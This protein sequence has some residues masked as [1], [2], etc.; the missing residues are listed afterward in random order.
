MKNL[1]G[2]IK[3][4]SGQVLVLAALL[5]TVLMG[6]AAFAVDIGMVTVT[7]AKLQSTADA[8]VL[9]AVQVLN[10]S[11]T[12]D[13]AINYAL[14]NGM[15]ATTNG[16][17]QSGDT[18]T[19]TTPYN[20]DSNLIEVVCSRNVKYTF[21]RVLGFNETKV[22]ARAVAENSKW[23]GDVL[24]FINLD[25]DGEDSN[26]G[27]PLTAWNKCDPSGV[28]E[29]INNDDLIIKTSSI[30]VKLED[31]S[32]IFKDGKDMSQVQEPLKN[33]LVV[34]KTVYI[35]S[36]KHS[37]MPNYEKKGPKELK[38]GDLIP[39]EDTVLLEC[40]VTDGW[41]GTGSDLIDLK[42]IKSYNWDASKKTYL[43]DEGDEPGG[44]IRLVK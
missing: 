28:K 44:S 30:K 15:K 19:V 25:G 29:R 34:G 17:E 35:I 7:K 41:T 16:V 13:V 26:E 6:F 42:F 27:E 39:L 33:I 3:N 5:M 40:E 14:Q 8:A 12:E 32:V 9:A 43:T 36:L 18:V 1:K 37:E 20:G 23:S 10:E 4:E 38:N 31:G 21:A 11:G 22:S 2:T 24:P